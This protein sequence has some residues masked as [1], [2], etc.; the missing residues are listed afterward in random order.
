M[1]ED[2]ELLD[3]K[4]ECLFQSLHRN[5]EWAKR[6]N[7]I[8]THAKSWCVAYWLIYVGSLVKEPSS[9]VTWLQICVGVLGVLFFLI[10]D[11]T[12]HYYSYLWHR[13]NISLNKVLTRLPDMSREELQAVEP[14]PS[15]TKIVL[16]RKKYLFI[17]SMLT[18]ETLLFFYFG[19]AL[20]M[21][22]VL[23]ALRYFVGQA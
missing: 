17:L 12:T 8:S 7:E 23:V 9:S 21:V 22:I 15:E 4:K 10:L 1:L 6:T 19:L 14:L 18:H 3:Y 5:L 16:P 13:Q 2:K 11:L 20:I